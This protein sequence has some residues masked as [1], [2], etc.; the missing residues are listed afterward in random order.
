MTPLAD[1]LRADPPEPFAWTFD[2]VL[3]LIL[4]PDRFF[5]HLSKSGYDKIPFVAIW[6][7]GVAGAINTSHVQLMMND[8]RGGA[9]N[10]SGLTHTWP[11]LWWAVLAAGLVRGPLSWLIGGWWYRVRL[12]FCGVVKPPPRQARYIYLYSSLVWS[13]LLLATTACDSLFLPNFDSAHVAGTFF[14]SFLATILWSIFISYRGATACFETRRTLA[15]VW[16][17]ILPMAIAA[18]PALVVLAITFESAF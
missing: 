4:R 15:R 5:R 3:D 11:M 18:A 10:M 14:W 6:A 8:I 13:V 1:S 9:G 12:G 7:W 17:L 16:F 2:T